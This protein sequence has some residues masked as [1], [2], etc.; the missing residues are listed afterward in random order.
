MEFG[1]TEAEDAAVGGDEPVATPVGRSSHPTMD[2]LS[3]RP[4]IDPWNFA[5]PKLKIPPSDATS[6]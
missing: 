5:S 2:R 6:Q 1:V 3:G 4:P